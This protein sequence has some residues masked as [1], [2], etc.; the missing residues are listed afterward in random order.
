M[1]K[2]NEM[3]AI[4]GLKFKHDVKID[5]INKQIFILNDKSKKVSK[6]DDLGIGSW[7]K[8]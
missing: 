2:H 4:L 1:A 8:N 5:A 6:K 7:G 3:S